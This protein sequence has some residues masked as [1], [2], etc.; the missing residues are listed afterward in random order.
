MQDQP[1]KKI[2][3]IRFSSIGDI[4]LTT[5]LLRC[6][7]KQYP[8]IEIH[9][10]TKPVFHII[11][12]NNFYIDKIHLLN[13]N[14]VSKALEL[15]SE[16]F[17][18]VI[19]IHH[20]LRTLLFKTILGVQSFSFPKLNFEKYLFVNFKINK[21]PKVHIVDRYFEAAKILA[22]KND[23]EGLDYF[24]PEKDQLPNFEHLDIKTTDYVTWAIGGQH[25]TKRLPNHKIIEF[26]KKS[27]LNI[28]LL[29]AAE[30]MGNAIEIKQGI[31]NN[32][33]NACEQLNL[34]QSAWFI[35]N[36]KRLYTNDTGLMHIAAA[37]KVPIT[38]FWGN[39]VSSFGM[40]PYYGKHL[41]EHTILENNQISCRPC[42][43]IGF[44]KCPRKH[45]KCMEDLNLEFKSPA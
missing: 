12:A 4:V 35:K 25:F 31:G 22:V 30:D 15:K 14:P 8:G 10:L 1:I 18:L 27:G 20:N 16:N 28:V 2:L 17:D 21:M 29:G 23:E 36:S 45:F 11:L 42:S 3:I 13:E 24:I 38:S 40:S 6:I 43:K 44:N 32:C 9:Y 39:T 7:K 41:I 26:C 37:L 33:I 19:D 5:P 34:N